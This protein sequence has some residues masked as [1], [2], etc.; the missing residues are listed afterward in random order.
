M[1]VRDFARRMD[2]DQ[3]R[4]EQVVIVDALVYKSAVSFAYFIV[5][6]NV[7]TKETFGHSLPWKVLFEA[8]RHN[9]RAVP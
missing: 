2:L 6:E 3:V 8:E 1:Q 4:Q 7:C 5:G 9:I